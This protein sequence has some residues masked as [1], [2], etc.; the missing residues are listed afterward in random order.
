MLSLKRTS[1]HVPNE[2]FLPSAVCQKQGNGKIRKRG[3]KV[4]LRTCFRR[5]PFRQPLPSIMLGN[6]R[7]IRNKMD[8]LR[9]S[10]QY[11]S[12]Y[13]QS[14]LICLSETWLAETDPESAIDLEGFSV[15]R[16]DCSASSGKSKGG[17]LCMFINNKYCSPSHVTVRNRL[18]TKDIE[19]LAVN[20]RPY[21]LLREIVSGLYFYCLHCTF[22]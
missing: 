11:L 13:H 9:A 12:D 17:G 6:V 21:H 18:C 15:V 10:V 2:L 22:C 14:C 16:A 8:E 20:L 4:G 7:S 1:L 19:L 3:R 5:K